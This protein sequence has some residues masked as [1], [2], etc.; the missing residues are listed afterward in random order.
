MPLTRD[1]QVR[2][3]AFQL[4]NSTQALAQTADA[5]EGWDGTDD[6]DGLTGG[7]ANG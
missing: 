2:A 6:R 1:P 4:A 5:N 7:R 3:D